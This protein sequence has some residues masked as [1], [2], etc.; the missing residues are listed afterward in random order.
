MPGT[1]LNTQ[2][3]ESQL[4]G[5]H[6]GFFCENILGFLRLF[7]S[8]WW[9][10]SRVLLGWPPRLLSC[11]G[12]ILNSTPIPQN[13]SGPTLLCSFL[14]ASCLCLR[15]CACCLPLHVSSLQSPTHSCPRPHQA[16]FSHP[17]PQRFWDFSLLRPL[18]EEM[19][20]LLRYPPPHLS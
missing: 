10:Q 2:V 9:P 15:S 14:M 6:G 3:Q 11:R 18:H 19:V 12:A 20:A 17:V 4:Q 7:V 8:S 16:P 13:R 1:G 5:K